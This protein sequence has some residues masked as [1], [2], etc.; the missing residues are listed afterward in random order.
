MSERVVGKL[1]KYFTCPICLDIMNK[2]AGI[3]CGHE[4]CYNCIK[5]VE[6]HSCPIC[7]VHFKISNIAFA[8]EKQARINRLT[9]KCVHNDKG[10]EYKGPRSTIA[11][12][13]NDCEFDEDVVLR[14]KN[15]KAEEKS[16]KKPKVRVP[17]QYK[18]CQIC[19]YY[20]S[21]DCMYWD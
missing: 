10:C 3:P 14:K 9:V 19:G 8:Y 16:N 15:E 7:R 13:E 18:D 6:Q 17:D 21:G 1:C 4:F 11:N 5:G 2:A 12:H 20:H